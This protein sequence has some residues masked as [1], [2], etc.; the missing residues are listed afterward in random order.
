MA[1]SKDLPLH[2]LDR[3]PVFLRGNLGVEEAKRCDRKAGNKPVQRLPLRQN[4]RALKENFNFLFC[5]N[6][7]AFLRRFVIY[8]KLTRTL[9]DGIHG[10]R[11]KQL[12]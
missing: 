7:N 3:E 9:D 4:E 12:L 5:L 6:S 11:G 10:R 2:L 8:N 1:F